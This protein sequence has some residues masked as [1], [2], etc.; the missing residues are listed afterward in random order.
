MYTFHWICE[1]YTISIIY[2]R[3]INTVRNTIQNGIL[4]Y[5]VPVR[6]VW[7]LCDWRYLMKIYP[8]GF[9]VYNRRVQK[10]LLHSSN[11]YQLLRVNTVD[12]R[13]VLQFNFISISVY[14]GPNH[15]ATYQPTHSKNS[16][17]FIVLLMLSLRFLHH[18]Y[19]EQEIQ[20]QTLQYA[21][22]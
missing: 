7:S 4:L 21:W 9:C 2:P 5:S 3:A 15:S 10:Y 16:M 11:P 18:D 6:E 1:T 17:S 19:S 14:L 20:I 22:W 8:P 12:Y 13:F